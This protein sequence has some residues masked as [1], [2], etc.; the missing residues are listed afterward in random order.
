MLKGKRA[1]ITGGA[2]G[3][4]LETAKEFVRQGADVLICARDGE[5]LE[6]AAE[7]LTAM[8][9]SGGQKV[10]YKKADVSKTA[11]VD[12]LFEYALSEFDGKLDVLVNNAGIQGPIG[13]FDENDWDGIV[14]TINVDLIGAL[15]CMRKA[16]SIFKKE[17]ATE[18]ERPADRCIINISGGGATKARPYFMAYAVAKTGLVRATDTLAKETEAY[19][20]RVNAV[21]PGAM[22]TRMMDEII[23][24][25]D[26]AGDEY[27]LSIERKAGGGDPLTEPAC[28]AAYLAS[29]KA[30]GIT[31]KL[32]SAKW[33][34]WREFDK[35]EEEIKGSD[36]YTIRRI[37]PKDLG[38]DWE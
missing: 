21:A 32:I 22:K 38:L 18:G 26:N 5:V 3:L 14:A 36:L 6:K 37:V 15:Y 2:R 27:Q 33:D 34:G 35:H 1:I 13:K 8:K 29:E 20:I 28:L 19:G 16:V 31:G 25:G 9:V 17:A 30:L 24:A 4:G 11:D 23:D 12:A 7:E 10:I